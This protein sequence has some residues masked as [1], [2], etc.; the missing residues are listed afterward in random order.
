MCFACL[1]GELQLGKDLGGGFMDLLRELGCEGGNA[2]LE[3][4]LDGEGI[5]MVGFLFLEEGG[6]SGKV[7]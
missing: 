1:E 3:R 5:L 2:Q 6:G 7:M 4:R